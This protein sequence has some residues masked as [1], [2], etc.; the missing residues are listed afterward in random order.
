MPDSLYTRQW[1]TGTILSRLTK[2]D[3]AALLKA[4][5]ER[6]VK[7]GQVLMQ[8]GATGSHAV[9]VIDPFLKITVS[10]A[11][12]KEALLS[13][14]VPGDLI[15]EVSI[16]NGRPRIATATACGPGRVRVLSNTQLRTYL[17]EHPSAT[18]ELAGVVADR[19]RWANDRRVDVATVSAP[20]RLARILMAMA[21]S[22]GCRT[23]A[24]IEIGIDLTQP[25]IA[26]LIGVSE[27]TAQRALR[28]LRQDGLIETG[29]RRIT[30]TN[31]QGL[32]DYGE[33]T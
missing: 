7:T 4:G 16:I 17:S 8:M 32:I 9:L 10:S 1:P 15:G 5:H 19:L 31:T 18:I 23:T 33:T 11:N 12:G 25:E 14:R 2:D 22:Y 3:R 13:I 24:G 28:R 30:V 29:Y 27:I 26:T 20:T 21:T 6:Q